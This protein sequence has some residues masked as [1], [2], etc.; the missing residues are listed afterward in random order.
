MADL[1]EQ[2]TWDAGVYQFEETDAV[3]GGPDGIDNKPLKNL[4]NRTR[5]LK[6]EVEKRAPLIDAALTGMPTAPTAV[7]GTNSNQ[8][9]TTAFLATALASLVD[10]SPETLDTLNELA[11]ALGDDE[12]F[13]ATMATALAGKADILDGVPIGTPSFCMT[14]TPPTGYLKR[15]GA[16][17]QRAGFSALWNF[18]TNNG[19]V[20]SEAAWLSGMQGYFAEGDGVNSFRLPEGRSLVIR[21]WDDA[22]GYDNNRALGSL[23]LDALQGFQVLSE[24]QL[25]Y[26][27]RGTQNVLESLGAGPQRY[28]QAYSQP[29][30]DDLGNGTPR[31]SHETRMINIAYTPI[32]KY[33]GIA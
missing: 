26:G 16:L 5:Y 27:G 29:I 13:A 1:P 22:Y 11:A 20:V 4:T 9:A 21:G 17:V 3:Q 7:P 23:Q 30:A 32:I 14:A 6:D 33:R 2:S 18:A 19:L 15:N 10:S 12:N 31:I 25:H 28:G 8:I 24:N